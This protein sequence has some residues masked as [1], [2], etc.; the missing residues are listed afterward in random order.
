MQNA[1]AGRFRRFFILR[2]AFFIRSEVALWEPCG[3]IGVALESQSVAYQPAL[4]WLYGGF[5]RLC[6]T[7]RDT[8]CTDWHGGKRAGGAR[9]QSDASCK[10]VSFVPGSGLG[11][12]WG[13]PGD[14]LGAV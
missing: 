3:R 4:W 8:D 13:Q 10:S 2:S 5:G 12:V 11:V 1:E 7:I 9:Q 14:S 6:P